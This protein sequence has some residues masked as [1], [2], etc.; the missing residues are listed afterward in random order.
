[1]RDATLRRTPT[2]RSR[3]R[4][5]ALIFAAMV[6]PNLALFA[7]F[8]YWPL[9][10]QAYLSLTDWN[11][12]SPVKEM[13]GL[14]NYADLLTDPEFGQIMLHTLVFTGGILVFRLALGLLFALLLNQRL[15]GRNLARSIVFAPTIVSG[16]AIG[17]V[18]AYIFD[19]RY[20]LMRVVLGW[21]GLSS[22]NWLQDGGWAMVAVIIVYL[23]RDVGYATIVYLA[24]LQGVPQELGEAARVDGAGAWHTFRHVTLPL[25]SPVTFFIVV[26][27]ILS[28]FQAF[29]IFNAMTGGGPVNA[30][31]TL[32]YYVYQQ[33]F[34]GLQVGQAATAGFLLFVIMLAATLVQLRFSRWVHYS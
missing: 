34:V 23:W 29:D 5:E 31:T 17:I 18:W 3:R 21:V 32:M 10:Y 33:G 30:T 20:G 27:T 25:L 24:G 16:A 12:L 28:S 9:V 2:R 4:R 7:V 1:M 14:Q 8:T 13:V 19:P 11:L 15:I 22:P 26:T 6:L